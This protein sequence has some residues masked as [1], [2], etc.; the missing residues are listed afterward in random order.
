VQQVNPKRAALKGSGGG[1][2]LKVDRSR[3]PS[4]EGFDR[5]RTRLTA[6]CCL[7]CMLEQTPPATARIAGVTFGPRHTNWDGTPHQSLKRAPKAQ[8]S[9]ALRARANPSFSNSFPR[10]H[11]LGLFACGARLHRVP[12]NARLGKCSTKQW[13]LAQTSERSGS[14]LLRS[15]LVR[16][17]LVVHLFVGHNFR[18]AA[19]RLPAPAAISD[20]SFVDELM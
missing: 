3:E 19:G 11:R 6:M 17:L 9:T 13:W 20:T 15:G 8:L 18:S 16:A 12:L 5:L 4:E 1:A 10:V 14:G 2:P 7:A